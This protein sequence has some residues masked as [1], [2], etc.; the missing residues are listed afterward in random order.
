MCIMKKAEK[1][2]HQCEGEAHPEREYITINRRN[3]NA[4][5]KL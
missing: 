3:W 4:K 5:Y 2:L 1:C